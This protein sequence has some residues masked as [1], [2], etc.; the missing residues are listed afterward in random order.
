MQYLVKSEASA[1][2]A[3]IVVARNEDEA[4]DI[5]LKEEWLEDRG[6]IIDINTATVILVER[7]EDGRP[8]RAIEDTELEEEE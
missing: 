4:A 1:I 2:H 8:L 5:Y 3:A 6:T 7:W